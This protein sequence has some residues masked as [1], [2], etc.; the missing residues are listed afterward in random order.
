MFGFCLGEFF[1]G[2]AIGLAL[3]LARMEGIEVSLPR[4][5]R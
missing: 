2:M 1:I 5:P 4:H 3:T